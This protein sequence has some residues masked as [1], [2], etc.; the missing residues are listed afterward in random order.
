M[1][2]DMRL[3]YVSYDSSPT[4]SGV[5]LSL[6]YIV[7]ED[8][9]YGFNTRSSPSKAQ[10]QYAFSQ[11]ISRQLILY[12]GSSFHNRLQGLERVSF[13]RKVLT[14]CQH[15]HSRGTIDGHRLKK[16]KIF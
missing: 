9:L 3:L 6:D 5:E 15:G 8:S 13:M 14:C 10:T 1:T 7:I 16:Q 4:I 11:A 2:T 12:R